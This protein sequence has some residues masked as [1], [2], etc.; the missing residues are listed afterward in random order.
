LA[1]TAVV[2][3][4]E[5]LAA[6]AAVVAR[7]GY[8]R[9]RWPTGHGWP[10]FR[11]QPV[12]QDRRQAGA[13]RPRALRCGVAPNSRTSRSELSRRHIGVAWVLAVCSTW[14]PR[15]RPGAAHEQVGGGET[16]DRGGMAGV[17]ICENRTRGP[18]KTA[19]AFLKTGV[20][21]PQRLSKPTQREAW[22]QPVVHSLPIGR[23]SRRPGREGS[24]SRQPMAVSARDT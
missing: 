19:G 11:Q 13:E 20:E 1:T 22:E 24:E 3:V 5:A 18:G 8:T 9:R 2:V 17:E 16:G 23:M 21:R 10:I 6:V 14:R 12:P 4:V 15:G 7:V